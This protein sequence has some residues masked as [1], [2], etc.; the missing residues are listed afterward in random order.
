LPPWRSW[1]SRPR[2]TCATITDPAIALAAVRES[3]RAACARAGRAE[4][5]VCLLAASKYADA[6]A[7]AYLAAAGQRTFGENRVQDAGA[8]LT[9]LPRQLRHAL[10]VHMIGHLQTNKARAA[11]EMFDMVESVDSLHLAAALGAAAAAAGKRLPVLLQVNVAADP[12]KSGFTVE[13]LMRDAERLLGIEAVEV[14][15]LMT[16]GRAGETPG[17]ARRTFR[18]LRG[19]RDRLASDWPPP[20]LRHLSMGMSGDYEV[21][22]EEGATIVRVGTALFGH[23][24]DASAPR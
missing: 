14:Q 5:D 18:A 15:G 19:L 23:H 3:V 20:A 7:I 2:R 6:A 8:K 21:A 13:Q 17:Q 4:T 9:E 24:H 22:I 10:A 11:V 16:M 12:A 1:T